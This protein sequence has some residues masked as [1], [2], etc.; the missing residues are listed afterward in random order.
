MSS[1][2]GISNA[3]LLDAN[4]HINGTSITLPALVDVDSA[5]RQSVEQTFNGR[6]RV[7]VPYD[8][9][10]LPDVPDLFD[11]HLRWTLDKQYSTEIAFLERLRTYGGTSILAYWKKHEYRYTAQSGQTLFYLPRVD[12]FTKGYTGKTADNYKAVVKVNGVALSAANTT[13][14]G[15]VDSGTSVSSAQVAIGT[16]A[17][18]PDSGA[19][20]SPFKFGTAKSQGDIITVEYHQLFNVCVMDVQT[21]P[22]VGERPFEENKTLRLAETN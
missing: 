2:S 12:A 13:Y 6:R 9:A 4:L 22:F 16:A 5:P 18:H 1:G 7:D 8:G 14:P 3:G 10:G 21:D 11:F 15:A 17:V 20:V 19:T